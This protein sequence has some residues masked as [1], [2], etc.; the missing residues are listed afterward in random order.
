MQ[1]STN[2]LLLLLCSFSIA[3]T[4]EI[5]I[6][7]LLTNI[8]KK[9]DL[10]S[11]TKL[12]NGGV[13][14]IYT[15]EDIHKMQAHNLKDILKSSY[16]FGYGENNFGTS[17]PYSISN[18]IP[19]VSSKLKIYIDNQEIS[20][21]LYGSGLV[22]Y[23]KMDIDFVDHIEVY[24]SNPTLEL[25]T[26]PASTIIKLYSRVAQKDDGSQMSIAGG[27][28]GSKEISGYTTSIL[29]NGWAYFVYASGIDNKRAKY[30]N[31]GTQLSRDTKNTHIV[32]TFTKEEQH[33][34]VDII[35]MNE[36]S[37]ISTSI[38]ATPDT[39]TLNNHFLHVGYD[40]RVN[41]ISFLAT[42]DKMD[43]K[44]N[45]KDRNQQTIQFINQKQHTYI[46][47]AFNTDGDSEVYTAGVNYDLN[48]L[49][50]KLVFGLK[51]RFKHFTYDKIQVN[52]SELPRTGHTHQIITTLFGENQ[53]FY[54]D[55]KIFTTGV[56]YAFVRNNHSNQD[57]NLLGYRLGYTYT[58]T[59][60]IAKT[61]ISYLESSLDPYL[62]HSIYLNHPEQK[63]P[64]EQQTVY[65]QN[66]KYKNKT[67]TY[68]FIA[69][70]IVIKNPISPS[71]KNGLLEAYP[72]PLKIFGGLARYVR[73][74]RDYD[75]FEISLD[76]NRIKNLS[77]LDDLTQYTLNLRNFNTVG[78]F[79]IFNEL[80]YYRDTMT[81]SNTYDYSAGIAYHATQD[82]TFSIK[83]TNLFNKAKD[84]GYMR[85]N[86]Q[87][88]TLDKPLQI[89]PIDKKIMLRMEYTF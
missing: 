78:K 68:D 54:A 23:G 52:G 84:S 8:E 40:T 46:P 12:E 71:P 33:F 57:D 39:S 25:S 35:N 87:T 1:S 22:I 86:P 7:T 41:N 56:S 43:T 37:F 81:K 64:K 82:L 17:D 61:I 49:S 72:E 18:A 44:T 83:G 4:D 30:E 11:Q 26:E 28:Y 89:S 59:K 58:N 66:I 65:I 31:Y 16:P 38:F 85:I 79:D 70:Y 34:L 6:D 76:I 67:T 75:K 20:T 77:V 50:N 19:F 80:L 53:Y 5:N 10:S 3:H 88:L 74:Y 45:F 27:S 2:L 69:N 48:T 47:Y 15:R 60:L 42:F 63:T 55:N 73:E 29:D 21:G 36:D 62:I 32:G 51:Y 13:Y 24:A 9:T 14:Y